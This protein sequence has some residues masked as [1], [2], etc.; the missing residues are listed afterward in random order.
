MKKALIIIIIIFGILIYGC[1]N[2]TKPAIP[3]P[4]IITIVTKIDQVKIVVFG[5]SEM[6]IDWISDLRI[7][8]V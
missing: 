6:I 3:E 8:G 7:L 2:T 5:K 1:N 4:C